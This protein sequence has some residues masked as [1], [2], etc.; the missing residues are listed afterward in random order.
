[1]WFVSLLP[2][3]S[4]RSLLQDMTTKRLTRICDLVMN[5][6]TVHC[7]QQRN[8]HII[9][10]NYERPAFGSVFIIDEEPKDPWFYGY[11]DYS[12]VDT[13][14]VSSEL[15]HEV[16]L[17]MSDSRVFCWWLR[18]SRQIKCQIQWCNSTRL[19]DVS[20]ESV[21]L[22]T[23]ITSYSIKHEYALSLD[24]GNWHNLKLLCSIFFFIGNITSAL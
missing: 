24:N 16:W 19:C 15:R 13:A 23:S 10:Q 4:P 17:K 3:E 8:L 11:Y 7:I 9:H 6:H 1:M 20:V 5:R 12:C 2:V 21:L 22:F 14:T 18:S